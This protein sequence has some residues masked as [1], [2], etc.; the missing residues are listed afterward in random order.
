LYIPRWPIETYLN[1]ID[2]NMTAYKV[3]NYISITSKSIELNATA[4]SRPYGIH[5]SCAGAT[6]KYLR[7]ELSEYSY[8]IK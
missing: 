1:H 4:I 6:D 5:M 7:F 2:I 3:Y 8:Y